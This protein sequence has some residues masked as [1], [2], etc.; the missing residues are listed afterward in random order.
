M[1]KTKTADGLKF[2]LNT[3]CLIENDALLAFSISSFFSAVMNL[4][5]EE[6]FIPRYVY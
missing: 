5:L 1:R 6:T 4:P 3:L 2:L